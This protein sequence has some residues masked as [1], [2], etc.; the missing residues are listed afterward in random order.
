MNKFRV[1]LSLFLNYF[2]FAILLNSVGSVILQVQH[3]FDVSK[4]AAS[5]LEAFK[6]LSIA[7][8]S[9]LLASSVRR[10]G[11]KKSMLLALLLVSVMCLIIPS[12]NYF[13]MVKLLFA[14]VG[15]GF[16]LVKVSVFATIGL[17][18]SDQKE[19][20]STMNFLESFFMVGIL[21]GY[22]LF[23]HFVD[24]ND[25][26]SREWF[27]AYYLLGALSL[28]A[29]FLLYSTP[30]DESAV[31]EQQEIQNSARDFM[32]MLQLIVKPLV[33]VFIFSAFLYVLIE[34][35]IMSWLP[36]FNSDVLK[37]SSSLSIQMASILSGSFALGRFLAGILLK[38]ID[39]IW[40]L[41]GCLLGAS[42]L[43][44]I[45]VPM[46][47]NVHVTSVNS[48]SEVP[49]VAFLFPLIGLLLAPV[50]PAIN[51]VI[52]SNLPKKQHA[53]M[54]GLIVVF[55]ALGGTTGSIIT[56]HIFDAWGGQVAFYCSLIPIAVLIGLLFLF[57]KLDRQISSTV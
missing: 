9:F 20:L 10:I 33:L 16:A 13:W 42:I 11:Y 52:L 15:V 14:S 36:T 54:S 26:H 32:D 22:F 29:F 17:V 5:V 46:A 56:G 24:N 47:G 41:S 2:V 3:N 30:L 39:W 25:P 4:G 21:A 12:L 7:I 19:H 37:L 44:L 27:K 45:T 49:A 8:A 43:V 55:S 53:S 51:S 34:Q 6:D 50:Y 1:K 38:K 23:A 48:L 40:L 31:H 28:L 18:T 35:S 57:R